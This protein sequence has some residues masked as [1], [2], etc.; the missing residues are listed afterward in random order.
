MAAPK[1]LLA[2]QNLLPPCWRYSLVQSHG[3]LLGHEDNRR[4]T[5]IRREFVEYKKGFISEDFNTQ[6]VVF[7]VRLFIS[8]RYKEFEYNCRRREVFNV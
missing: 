2:C 3:K 1:S 4:D 7:R 6:K 8:K 5:R